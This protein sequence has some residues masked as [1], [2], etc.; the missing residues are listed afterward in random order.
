MYN[1]NFPIGKII[2]NKHFNQ[3]VIENDLDTYFNIKLGNEW[4]GLSIRKAMEEKS[5]IQ[6]LLMWVSTEVHNDVNMDIICI[7]MGLERNIKCAKD[8]H[9][10]GGTYTNYYQVTSGPKDIS[11][12]LKT[13]REAFMVFKKSV[14]EFMTGVN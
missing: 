5:L 1:V 8:Y 10:A 13:F 9:E 7:I 4:G 11:G 3:I 2:T 14:N 12:R 6:E